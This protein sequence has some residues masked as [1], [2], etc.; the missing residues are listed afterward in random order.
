MMNAI[1]KY[2]TFLES[3]TNDDNKELI[4]I[5]SEGFNSIHESK[6]GVALGGAALV[7]AGASGLLNNEEEMKDMEERYQ[8]NQKNEVE[9]Q[10]AQKMKRYLEMREEIRSLGF[11]PDSIE[12]EYEKVPMHYKD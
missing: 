2:N 9:Y 12:M 4:A 5:V 10:N 7:A 8:E 1:T 6:A 3:I 11:D